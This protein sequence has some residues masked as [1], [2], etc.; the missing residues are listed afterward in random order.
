MTLSPIK[1]C[2]PKSPIS[3]PYSPSTCRLSRIETNE[4]APSPRLLPGI[5]E[6][7]EVLLPMRANSGGFSC[8]CCSR[9]CPWTRRSRARLDNSG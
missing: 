4:S 6:D 1:D 7:D 3:S 8:H 5:V 2:R 9:E